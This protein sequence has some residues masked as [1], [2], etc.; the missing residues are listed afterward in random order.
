MGQST[1]QGSFFLHLVFSPPNP[2]STTFPPFSG[3][4]ER[5]ETAA[6]LPGFVELFQ[7]A[8]SHLSIPN[9]SYVL[10]DLER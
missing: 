8:V 10:V 7:S 2:C 6:P 5:K 4:V 1:I 9:Y 3:F